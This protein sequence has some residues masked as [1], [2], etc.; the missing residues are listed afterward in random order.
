MH[1]KIHL[2]GFDFDGTKSTHLGKQKEILLGDVSQWLTAN[3]SVI[4]CGK[5]SGVFI[6][7][8]GS[9][10]GLKVNWGVLKRDTSLSQSLSPVSCI[11]ATWQLNP[12][13]YN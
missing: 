11:R 1:F 7:A 13:E 3:L 6:N 8:L 9:C 2:I 12:M 5:C 10:K 4:S